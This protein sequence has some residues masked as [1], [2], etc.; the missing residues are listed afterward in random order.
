VT[1]SLSPKVGEKGTGSCEEIGWQAKAPAPQGW[2][3]FDRKMGQ[4][5]SSVN[6]AVR[7]I[8]SQLPDA[9]P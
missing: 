9:F 1:F 3:S 5:L 8:F 2:K 6:P 7:P 4:T